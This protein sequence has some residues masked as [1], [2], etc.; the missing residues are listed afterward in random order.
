MA[1][2]TTKMVVGGSQQAK[3]EEYADEIPLSVMDD[4]LTQEADTIEPEIRH[5]ANTMLKGKYWTGTTALKLTRK[6]PHT[7]F[8][9]VGNGQRQI[10]LTFK[11]LRVR[12][13][14]NGRKVKTK[15]RNAEIAFVNEYGARGIPARPFIKQGIEK[16][17]KEAFDRAE[18]VFD[19]W[20]NQ[21]NM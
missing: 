6:P 21:E 4:M 8:G 13:R 1:K 2:V 19:K 15:T 9:K 10:A 3:F 7:W 18:A 17:E 20:L 16:K 11:G 12:E 14:A 5:N